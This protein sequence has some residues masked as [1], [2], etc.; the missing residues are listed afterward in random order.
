MSGRVILF[1]FPKIK[2]AKEWYAD[3]EYQS[4]S[5]FRRKSVTTTL[6]MVNGLA[7]R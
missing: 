1:N 7:P 6:T 4:L 2:N 3:P 5:E